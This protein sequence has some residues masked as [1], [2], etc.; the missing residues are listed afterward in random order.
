MKADKKEQECKQP[1]E[2]PLLKSVELMTNEVLAVGCKGSSDTAVRSGGPPCW[3]SNCQ[4]Q[5][6]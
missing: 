2:K 3:A 6:S 4:G 5:G 1:Y